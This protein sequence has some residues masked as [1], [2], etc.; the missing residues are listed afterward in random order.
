MGGCLVVNTCRLHK[1]CWYGKEGAGIGESLSVPMRHE[2]HDARVR[3]E[4][5]A[6]AVESVHSAEKSYR[7]CKERILEFFQPLPDRVIGTS[8]VYLTK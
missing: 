5:R 1:I 7:D 2:G 8:L 4:I 3:A 6:S